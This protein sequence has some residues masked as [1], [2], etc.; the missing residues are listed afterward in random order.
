MRYMKLAFQYMTKNIL[1]LLAVVIVPAILVGLTTEPSSMLM[2]FVG[3]TDADYTSFGQIFLAQSEMNWKSLLISVA[4]IPIVIA[5]ISGACGMVARQMRYGVVELKDFHVRINN[6]FILIC[7]T[8]F[9]LIVVSQI[10]AVFC[11]AATFFWVKMFDDK[12]WALSLT[13]I[14][15]SLTMFI[16]II[17]GS[18]FSLAVPTMSI[19]GLGMRSGLAESA[20][21]IKGHFM[22]FLVAVFVP[23]AIPY[24]IICTLAAYDFWW[25]RFI[26]PVFFVFMFAYYISLL[27]ATYCDI[28][29]V[30]REDLKNKYSF[31]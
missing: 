4:V 24:T 12:L 10:Y 14:F 3:F 26:Y 29:D 23:I 11:S 28:A 1:F 27:Y 15:N 30:D 8:V 6:N 5:F 22:K 31:N 17:V 20:K 13:I 7:K 18:L 16:F 25:R 2:F 19:T 9:I 21:I